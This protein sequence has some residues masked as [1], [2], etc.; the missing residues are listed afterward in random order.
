MR[1]RLLLASCLLLPAIMLTI[2]SCDHDRGAPVAAGRHMKSIPV[3]TAR[4]Q[5]GFLTE[6]GT[7]KTSFASVFTA[8]LCGGMPVASDPSDHTG[9]YSNFVNPTHWF[10]NQHSGSYDLHAFAP[11]PD[12]IA[13]CTL[14]VAL[15]ANRDNDD[16]NFRVYFT[17]TYPNGKVTE[18]TY[19]GGKVCSDN[20]AY[21][22]RYFPLA[23][24]SYGGPAY[25]N[26]CSSASYTPP[27]PSA[28]NEEEL[29]RGDP[30]PPGWVITNTYTGAIL[31]N[32]TACPVAPNTYA[33]KR[34]RQLVNG[35]TQLLP[36]PQRI[37]VC[38]SQGSVYPTGWATEPDDPPYPDYSRC[39][40]VDVT[41]RN[42]VPI[43]EQ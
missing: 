5:V 21:V 6:A 40:P 15:K 9:F 24:P 30:T 3:P 10:D 39:L 41:V 16:W 14:K 43:H 4:L 37:L 32:G 42:V 26:D 1:E 35:T 20:H 13:Q 38:N 7:E 27:P 2:S 33:I 31:P 23:R 34:V 17:W 25:P 19:E 29:C 28:E 12:D 22:A 8:L 36:K 18:H 11:L